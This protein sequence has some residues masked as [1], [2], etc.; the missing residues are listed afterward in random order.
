MWGHQCG[1]TNVGTPMWGHQCGNTNVGAPMWGHQCGGT[2]VGTPMW[3]HQ[4]GGT[5]VG[6]PMWEYQCGGT[7]VGTAMWGHQCGSTN[8]G[9][10][11]NCCWLRDS[12]FCSYSLVLHSDTVPDFIAPFFYCPVYT[13]PSEFRTIAKFARFRL[14]TPKTNSEPYQNLHVSPVYTTKCL[15]FPLSCI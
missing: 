7:N 12:S 11:T 3:G 4:C 5:N 10:S 15:R 2:N 6:T 9:Q 14:F 1:S 13:V 8:V